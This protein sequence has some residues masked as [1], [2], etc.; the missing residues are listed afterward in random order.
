MLGKYPM[1]LAA[2]HDIQK[3]NPNLL[4]E[5]S[6]TNYINFIR[7]M[8]RVFFHQRE[9]LSCNIGGSRGLQ[10]LCPVRLH[11]LYQLTRGYFPLTFAK[12]ERKSAEVPAAHVLINMTLRQRRNDYQKKVKQA[13]F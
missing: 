1:N 13:S 10:P 7:I 9:L 8:L 11:C 6:T 5:D 12:A 3:A 2:F 4:T